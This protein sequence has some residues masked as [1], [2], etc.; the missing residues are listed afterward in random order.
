VI[1]AITTQ[2]SIRIEG[3]KIKLPKLVFIKIKRAQDRIRAYI[4]KIFA[5]VSKYPFRPVF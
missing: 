3:S 2:G 4:S 1:Q 5:T